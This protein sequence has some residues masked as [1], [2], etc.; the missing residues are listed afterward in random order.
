[1]YG[2]KVIPIYKYVKPCLILDLPYDSHRFLLPLLLQMPSLEAQ[3]MKRFVKICKTMYFREYKS[4]S[5]VFRFCM[6]R[7]NSLMGKKMFFVCQRLGLRVM[8]ILRVA[9]LC[10]TQ[11]M[12]NEGRRCAEFVRELLHLRDALQQ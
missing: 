1:M 6:E 11:C 9:S 8:A 3:L 4:V 2:F 7:A 10:I 12:D 5:F